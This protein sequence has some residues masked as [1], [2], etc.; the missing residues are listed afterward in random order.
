MSYILDALT[1][2]QKQRERSSI[3]TLTTGYPVKALSQGGSQSWQ[4]ASIGLVSAAIAV[5][6]AVYAMSNDFLEPP[7][8]RKFLSA[9]AASNDVSSEA[10]LAARIKDF[11]RRRGL[12]ADGIAGPETLIHLSRAKRDSAMP[13]LSA[14][15]VPAA[16]GVKST[17]AYISD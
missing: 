5:A 12:Y 2:S 17:V 9:D 7:A 3:P 1:R 15:S 14:A 13:R 10:A 6:I 16:Q 8:Q 11:Q 4:G